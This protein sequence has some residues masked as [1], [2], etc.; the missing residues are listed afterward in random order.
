MSCYGVVFDFL[1]FDEIVDEASNAVEVADEAVAAA[2]AVKVADEAVDEIDA[3]FESDLVDTGLES[4]L[5]D[6]G[7]ESG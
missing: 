4:D 1:V 2:D 6:T 3:G 7:F 5:V